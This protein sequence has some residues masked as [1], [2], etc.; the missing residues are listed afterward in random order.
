MFK[1]LLY[2]FLSGEIKSDSVWARYDELLHNSGV[3]F[4][5]DTIA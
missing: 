2:E 5:R 3:A 4:I 1:P